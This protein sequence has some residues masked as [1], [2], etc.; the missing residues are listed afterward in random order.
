[1]RL[2]T[3]VR[4]CDQFNRRPIYVKVFLRNSFVRLKI[5]AAV[6]TLVFRGRPPRLSVVPS[7]RRSLWDRDPTE[8][9]ERCSSPTLIAGA[10]PDEGR[11]L[12]ARPG[13]CSSGKK[14]VGSKSLESILY[15]LPTYRA[16]CRWHRVGARHRRALST[17][18]QRV[19]TTGVSTYGGS[20]NRRNRFTRVASTPRSRRSA[21]QSLL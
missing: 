8:W 15:D 21:S 14:N 3:S 13:F 20:P 4:R 9:D 6:T 18:R 10:S 2:Y 5:S 16:S 17:C 12:E 7:G 19:E 1:M 11:D